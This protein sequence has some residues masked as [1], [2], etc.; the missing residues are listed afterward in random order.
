[1]HAYVDI[2]IHERKTQVDSA[3]AQLQ[4]YRARYKSKLKS[5]NKMYVSQLIA[6]VVGIRA[7]L[8]KASGGGNKNDTEAAA[9]N[10]T[11]GRGNSTS[12]I[13]GNNTGGGLKAMSK[14]V[15]DFTFASNIDHINLFK[16]VT[17][18]QV[19]RIAVKVQGLADSRWQQQQQQQQQVRICNAC[20]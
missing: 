16:L 13:R 7:Y 3:Y 9:T 12:Y 2:D 17:Y 20:V 10:K 19:S 4:A 18:I 8:V 1:M 6:T 15:V 5:K 14:D 11:P